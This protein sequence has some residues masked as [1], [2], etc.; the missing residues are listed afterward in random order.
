[1]KKIIFLV[2]TSLAFSFMGN[3][4]SR[5]YFI[6]GTGDSIIIRSNKLYNNNY[7]R[8]LTEA[9]TGSLLASKQ[10]V[11]YMLTTISSGGITTLNGLTPTSQNF[12]T[13]G[14]G[15]SVNSS[16]STHTFTVD[17]SNSIWNADKLRNTAIDAAT[18][19]ANQILM[20][21]SGKWTPTTPNYIQNLSIGTR[22]ATVLPIAI[23]SGTGVDLPLFNSTQ[24]G[25]VPASGS[26]TTKVLFANG[27]WKNPNKISGV[28]YSDMVTLSSFS[29]TITIPSGLTVFYIKVFSQGNAGSADYPITSEYNSGTGVLT[30]SSFGLSNGD[31]VAIHGKY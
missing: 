5:V 31:K 18:P 9:D 16:G 14:G 20:F 10:W 25:T 4:Q 13:S 23:S 17:A 7:K 15:I 6:G 21:T 12:A 19:S 11:N 26:D 8:Y 27:T 24:A 28:A 2:L 30:L 29:G 22:T 1:M 3:A